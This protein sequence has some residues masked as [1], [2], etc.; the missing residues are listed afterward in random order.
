VSV[1][2]V[3][4]TPEDFVGLPVS[5]PALPPTFNDPFVVSVDP[6]VLTRLAGCDESVCK[7]LEAN[8]F[9]PSNVPSIRFPSR[10]EVPCSPLVANNNANAKT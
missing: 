2:E 6:E 1:C 5:A 3:V 7:K 9:S 4:D 10:E 8:G